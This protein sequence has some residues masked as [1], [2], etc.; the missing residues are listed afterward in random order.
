MNPIEQYSNA[1]SRPAPA[2][3]QGLVAWLRSCP[4]GGLPEPVPRDEST[5]FI[6]PDSASLRDL[7][8]SAVK[9]EN[10]SLG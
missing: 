10:Q 3:N 9:I 4:G 7:R 6:Y 5:D 2:P 1:L 8:A